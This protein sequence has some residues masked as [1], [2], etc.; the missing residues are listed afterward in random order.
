ME[1]DSF[2]QISNALDR[3]GLIWHPELGDEIA[4]REDL[5]TIS[6]LVDPM[7]LTPGELRQRF[8]W[9]PTVEQMVRQFEARQALIQHLGVNQSLNYEAVIQTKTGIIETTA[10]SVRTLLGTALEDLL[11]RGQTSAVH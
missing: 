11:V 3:A 8:L 5:T 9:L 2:I 1:Q 6:I 10:K 4:K 7:S